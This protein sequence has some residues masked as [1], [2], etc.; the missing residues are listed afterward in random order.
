MI[1]F[2]RKILTFVYNALRDFLKTTAQTCLS[3]YT[4][5]F[6]KRKVSRMQTVHLYAICQ[7]IT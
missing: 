2:G 5:A 1:S 7:K 6:K 4:A 3:Q